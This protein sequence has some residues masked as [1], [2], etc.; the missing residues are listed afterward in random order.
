MKKLILLTISV[1]FAQGVS[2]ACPNGTTPRNESIEGRPVCTIQ[3]RYLNTNLT[4]N[5]QNSYVLEGDVRIGGDNSGMATLTIEPG[6]KIYGTAGAFLVIMRGSQIFANGTAEQPVVFTSLQRTGLRPGL[7]GGVVIN[8][9][10]PINPCAAGTPV[11]E[12]RSEGIKDDAPLFGGNNSTDNSGRLSYVRVEYAGHEIAPNNELNGITFNGVGSMT[13]VNHIQ[14]HRNADDGIE[15][16]GGTVNLKYVVLTDNDDDG[17]DWDF[18]WAGSAQ[19]VLIEIENGTEEVNGIE[20][21]NFKD[22]HS[23]LPRSNPTLSNITIIGKVQNPRAFHGIMLKAGSGMQMYNSIVTGHWTTACVKLKDTET[24]LNGGVPFA[25]GVEQKGIKFVNIFSFCAAGNDFAD[26]AS[27]PFMISELFVGASKSESH[28]VD[29]MLSG[30]RPMESSP[31]FGN[32]V[33]PEGAM[34][35]SFTEVDFA[36]ALSPFEEEDWTLGWTI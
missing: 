7:W 21:D 33:R 20:G 10:A 18:G 15:I 25:G 11:C 26:S 16:F 5:A 13:D 9:N 8:G 2:A 22:N 6:T 30:R 28:V 27:D 14:V 19:F 31:V 4:L 29:P 34:D 1:I 23:V 17:L 36:G 3:G 12:A 24:F 32:W 35:Y